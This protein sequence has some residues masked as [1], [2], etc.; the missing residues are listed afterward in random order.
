MFGIQLS[1]HSL[2][3]VVFEI[4]IVGESVI[5]TGWTYEFEVNVVATFMTGWQ[6]GSADDGNQMR[7]SMLIMR[8]AIET[9]S[10]SYFSSLEYLRHKGAHQSAE[11]C[12]DV[13]RGGLRAGMFTSKTTRC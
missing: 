11:K 10:W 12:L 9:I 2:V 4:E 8:N 5:S 3:L 6:S 7:K 13:E 1:S